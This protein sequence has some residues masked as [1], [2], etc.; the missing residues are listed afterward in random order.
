MWLEQKIG[1]TD[2][3]R[4]RSRFQTPDFTRYAPLALALFDF[5]ESSAR[6]PDQLRHL[7][8][9]SDGVCTIPTMPERVFVADRGAASSRATVHPTPALSSH[10]RGLAWFATPGPGSASG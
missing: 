7:T 2:A 9:A 10:W 3:D 4:L 8:S 5:G 6:H 1:R